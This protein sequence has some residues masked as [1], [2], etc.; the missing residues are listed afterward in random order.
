MIE[1]RPDVV[2]VPTDWLINKS[3]VQRQHL[4]TVNLMLEGLVSL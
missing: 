1:D 2:M 4:A 3:I